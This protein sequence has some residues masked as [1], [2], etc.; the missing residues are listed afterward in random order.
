[1]IASAISNNAC[2]PILRASA[3]DFTFLSISATFLTL[4][5]ALIAFLILRILAA[6]IA[7]SRMNWAIL[8]AQ[9]RTSMIPAGAAVARSERVRAELCSG[10]GRGVRA[11]MPVGDLR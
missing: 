8:A 5:M 2:P 1:M 9:L 6:G 11:S 4:P 10:M 7:F 3:N